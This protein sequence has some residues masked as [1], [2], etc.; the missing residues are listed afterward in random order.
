MC[1]PHNVCK[2]SRV[3]RL[4][5]CDRKRER[6]RE[7]EGDLTDWLNSLPVSPANTLCESPSLCGGWVGGGGSCLAGQEDFHVLC[8]LGADNEPTT[9]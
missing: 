8:P 1:R 6:E 7:G 9:S 4:C 2:Y 5:V 3:V